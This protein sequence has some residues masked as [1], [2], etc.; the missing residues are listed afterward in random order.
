MIYDVS[1]VLLTGIFHFGS[2]S[3]FSSSSTS[4][5]LSSINNH[6]QTR[7]VPTWAVPS[8]ACLI[9]QGWTLQSLVMMGTLYVLS[10]LLFC[11]LKNMGQG[12]TALHIVGFQ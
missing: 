9:G 3:T 11:D 2:L 7:A 12:G 1:L 4:T 6:F 5:T 8:N 10:E